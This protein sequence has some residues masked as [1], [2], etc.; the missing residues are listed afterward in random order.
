[1][2]IGILLTLY[3]E[4]TITLLSM[5]LSLCILWMDAMHMAGHGFSP[6]LKK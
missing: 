3:V 6:S 2:Y 4:Y 5:S 1:M